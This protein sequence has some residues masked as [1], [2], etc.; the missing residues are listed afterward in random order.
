[1]VEIN[2]VGHGPPQRIGLCLQTDAVSPYETQHLLP[3]PALSQGAT[4]C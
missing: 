3:K 4:G 2:P 1:V